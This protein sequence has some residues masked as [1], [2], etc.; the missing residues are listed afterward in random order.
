MSTDIPKPTVCGTNAVEPLPPGSIETSNHPRTMWTYCGTTMRPNP[1][2]VRNSAGALQFADNE[3]IVL[4]HLAHLDTAPDQLGDSHLGSCQ[5]LRRRT[6]ACFALS[7]SASLPRQLPLGPFVAAQVT[8]RIS[9]RRDFEDRLLLR[10]ASR[11]V[12]FRPR[13]ARLRNAACMAS[14]RETTR[15]TPKT[16]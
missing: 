16:L 8:R 9:S 14:N 4:E 15:A 12:S 13:M 1:I 11:L 10:P 2:E 6:S 3:P 7:G 5:H